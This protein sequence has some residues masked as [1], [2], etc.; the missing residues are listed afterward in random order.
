VSWT[1]GVGHAAAGK[2]LVPICVLG[3]H[4]RAM[5]TGGCCVALDRHGGH[6]AVR[7]CSISPG[8]AGA[9]QNAWWSPPPRARCLGT[10][11]HSSPSRWVR[12]CSAVAVVLGER[13]SEQAVGPDAI[14]RRLAMPPSE[15]RG[16]VSILLR[17]SRVPPAHRDQFGALGVVFNFV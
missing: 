14:P 15:T 11:P 9:M 5:A 13:G 3:G 17:G 6:R 10:W 16:L 12:Q 1:P 4:V 7:C 8:T 2:G